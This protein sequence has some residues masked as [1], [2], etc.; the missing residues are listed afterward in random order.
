[1]G[2]IYFRADQAR[3][4]LKSDARQRAEIR[5]LRAAIKRAADGDGVDDD[6]LREALTRK[7]KP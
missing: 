1:M 3:D 2:D 6:E 7:A 4:V 5:R